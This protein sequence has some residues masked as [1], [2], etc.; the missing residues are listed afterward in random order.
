VVSWL[1]VPAN[2]LAAADRQPVGAPQID[3]PHRGR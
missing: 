3:C 2:S 1:T